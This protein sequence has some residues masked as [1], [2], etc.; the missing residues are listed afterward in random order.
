MDSTASEIPTVLR[1]LTTSVSLGIIEMLPKS[2][3]IDIYRSSSDIE[4]MLKMPKRYISRYVQVFY[5]PA[6]CLDID[7]ASRNPP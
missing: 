7:Y 5:P 1:Y 4:T 3:S 6:V 2:G